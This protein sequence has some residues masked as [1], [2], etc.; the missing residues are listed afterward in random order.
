M[1]TS[2]RQFIILNGPPG[3][4]KD[5]IAQ[6]YLDRVWASDERKVDVHIHPFK[7]RLYKDAFGCVSAHMDWHQ[8]MILCRH[9]VLKNE[10]SDV[11]FGLSPR[12]FLIHV[13]EKI[14]KP[15]HGPDY[16]GKAIIEDAPKDGLI[17]V[18]DGGFSSELKTMLQAGESYE[19]IQVHREGTSFE[20]DSR[21]WLG[22]NYRIDNNGTITEAVNQLYEFIQKLPDI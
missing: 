22:S 1:S 5:S 16:F 20:G 21:G 8:F 17:L 7:H 15:I 12:Q 4:G 2:K 19:V 9:R 11:F 10:P 18:P 13:S 14:K 6:G 3:S